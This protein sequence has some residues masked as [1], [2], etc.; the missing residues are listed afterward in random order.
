MVSSING[1]IKCNTDGLCKPSGQAACGGVF[2]NHRGFV[3]GAFVQKLGVATAY[4]AEFYAVLL[5][6]ELAW[7]RGWCK[8][9]LEMDSAITLGN[10][11]NAEYRPHWKIRRRW[12]KCHRLLLTMDIRTSHIYREANVPADI[13]SNIALNFDDFHWWDSVFPAIGVAVTEDMI[14][15]TKYR[16]C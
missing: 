9:W 15:R 7:E 2:R 6:I 8:L 14:G 10:F 16:F 3:C 11:F 12:E 1:W 5:A 4:Y 13:M